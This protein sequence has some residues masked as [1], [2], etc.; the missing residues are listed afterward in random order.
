MTPA[1][2]CDA[3]CEILFRQQFPG[4][5]HSV[6]LDVESIDAALRADPA[7]KKQR[8]MTVAH[9]R[10]DDGI[11]GTDGPRKDFFCQ[12]PGGLQFVAHTRKLL[13]FLFRLNYVEAG[14]FCQVHTY[15]NKQNA[16]VFSR[17]FWYTDMKKYE[18]C[19]S[20]VK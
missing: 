4:G 15:G 2:Q 10:V 7:G 19:R 1:K 17:A 13:F 14:P 5:F 16:V 18:K 6:L 12:E 9:G 20:A 3:V 11:P 8:I